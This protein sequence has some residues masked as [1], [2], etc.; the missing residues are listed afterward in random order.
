VGLSQVS[1]GY[2]RSFSPSYL[3][4]F[5]QR[6]RVYLNSVYFFAQ[7]FVLSLG[8][9]YSHISRPDAFFPGPA[10]Q[11]LQFA[12]ASDN[13]VDGQLFFEYRPGAAVGINMTLRADVALNAVAVKVAPG[14][15]PT[16]NNLYDDIQFAR[17]QAF[18]GLRWFL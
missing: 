2:V 16:G 10:P 6:D 15:D 18:L 11:E 1:L 7:R 3:G 5:Y 12:A 8:G 4:S 14:N 9:G 17:Y 13:R